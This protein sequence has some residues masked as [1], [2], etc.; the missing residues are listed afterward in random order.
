MQRTVKELRERA[1]ELN[2]AGRWDMTKE[3]LE[4]AITV[5]ENSQN[6]EVVEDTAD[7]DTGEDVTPKSKSFSEETA[8]EIC[9]EEKKDVVIDHEAK[10]K[11]IQDAEVGTLVAFY[12]DDGNARSAKITNK[13]TKRQMLKLENKAGEEF[14]V[15]WSSVIWVRSG[16]RW[17]NGVFEL[18]TG[19]RKNGKSGKA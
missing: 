16:K 6:A 5:A 1:K 13:S 10:S 11:Y 15:P 9:G 19:G 17:P 3:Q 12:D 4:E 18:L 7:V 14:I 8:A 2:I